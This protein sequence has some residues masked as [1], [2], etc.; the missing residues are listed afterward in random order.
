MQVSTYL[1][2]KIE[3]KRILFTVKFFT[4]VPNF[5][6]EM[7]NT[8]LCSCVCF[9]LLNIIWL[10]LEMGEELFVMTHRKNFQKRVLDNKKY[11]SG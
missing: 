4:G 3:I 7:G 9:L 5:P 11:I 10:A 1:D 6:E 2:S 8:F